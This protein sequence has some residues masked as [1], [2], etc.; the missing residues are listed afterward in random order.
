MTE[1]HLA[2]RP[3]TAPPA[4]GAYLTAGG[5][6]YFLPRLTQGDK[7][8]FH[9]WANAQA[10]ADLRALEPLVGP[11]RGEPTPDRPLTAAE[12]ARAWD[13]TTARVTS[14]F[15]AFHEPG[16]IQRRVTELGMTYLC[17][18]ALRRHDPDVTW[19]EVEALA[20][21]HGA[22]LADA[23]AEANADPNPPAPASGRGTPTPG[24]GG[25]SSPS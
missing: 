23:F 6:S 19:A 18:L 4:P 21:R 12:Y 25:A 8:L 10:L 17:F 5:R 16:G 11:A 24:T 1:E 7:G 14:G 9:A 15:Y 3:P 2:D 20:E 13:Q 22:A